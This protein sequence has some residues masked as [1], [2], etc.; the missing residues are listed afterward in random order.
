MVLSHFNGA[1]R[2]LSYQSNEVLYIYICVCVNLSH[3]FYIFYP[4]N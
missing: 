4:N 1:N 2:A 3:S